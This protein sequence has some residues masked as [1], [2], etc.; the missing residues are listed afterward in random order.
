VTSA[1][2]LPGPSRAGELEVRVIIPF[3]H[4]HRETEEA[5]PADAEWYD[6]GADPHAY[7]RLLR[8]V[9]ADG[10]TFLI[11]EHDVV[12]R[13]DVLASLAT[14]PEPWCAFP[15]ADMC[16]WECMEAWANTLGCTRFSAEIIAACPDAV[17]SLR[18]ELRDWRNLCDHIAGDKV[19]GTPTVTLR[20]GSLR[21]AGYTHHWHFPAVVHH[22]MGRNDARPA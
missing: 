21:A 12:C 17:S 9:W 3:T 4:R 10:G 16:H 14:C 5:A 20:P 2:P 22:H 1:A 18:E 15:Y 8:D 6:V 11:V 7:W 13:P 19:D